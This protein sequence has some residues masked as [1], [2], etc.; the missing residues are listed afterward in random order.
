LATN[1]HD[2]RDGQSH[3]GRDG[4][5]G[6]TA[7]RTIAT[8]GFDA[9]AARA[10]FE[11]YGRNGYLRDGIP[12]SA[13]SRLYLRAG[14]PAIYQE[15]DFGLR[16]VGALETLLDPIL[17]LLDSLDSHVKPELAPND[18]LDLLASWLGVELDEAWS[19]DRRRDL[20]RSAAELSRWRGT[21]QG[22][23]L[24][25]RIAFPELPLR[26]EETGGVFSADEP[27]KLPPVAEPGFVVYCDVPLSEPMQASV[28]RAIEHLKPIHI[29]Y[30][31]R[32]KAPKR[33][34]EG[35]KSS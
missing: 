23:E 1:S 26:V 8:R 34:G 19:E 31:L 29:G 33:S 2:G 27:S 3:D 30:R 6:Q 25:L 15:G 12:P 17:A 18:M 22:L 5:D 16:F 24:E 13:S 14:L 32:V 28:A 10:R 20:V 21:R 9:A 7:V 4:R 35:A 11:R